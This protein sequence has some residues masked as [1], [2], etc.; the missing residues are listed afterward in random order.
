MWAHGFGHLLGDLLLD[1]LGHVGHTNR[2]LLFLVVGSE[3][4]GGFVL[5]LLDE[6]L[7]LLLRH[8]ALIDQDLQKI[9]D[10]VAQLFQGLLLGGRRCRQSEED[11]EQSCQRRARH[12][13]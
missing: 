6:L 12:P 4:S 1:D 11:A 3:V 7:R 2:A 5:R 9:D 10:R 8:D 13:S